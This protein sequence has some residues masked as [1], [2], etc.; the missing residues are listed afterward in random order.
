MPMLPIFVNNETGR[1]AFHNFHVGKS[2]DTGGS[3]SGSEGASVKDPKS[4]LTDKAKDKADGL[5]KKGKGLFKK[6]K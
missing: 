1:S 6:K 5:L 4:S 3:P 2:S